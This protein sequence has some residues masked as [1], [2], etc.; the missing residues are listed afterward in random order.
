[1][2]ARAECDAHHAA[3]IRTHTG[4]VEQMV[5][6]I[7]KKETCSQTGQVKG[8]VRATQIRKRAQKLSCGQDELCLGLA[9]DDRIVIT[10]LWLHDDRKELL[11]I[12]A[13]PVGHADDDG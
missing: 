12:A 11:C 5:L 10:G 4:N 13:A 7:F 3:V 1:M 2:F 8:T 6:K 9:D